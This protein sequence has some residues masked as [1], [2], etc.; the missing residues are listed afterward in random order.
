M[1]LQRKERALATSYTANGTSVLFCAPFP[2]TLPKLNPRTFE[3]LRHV[4]GTPLPS[5]PWTDLYAD[6]NLPIQNERQLL[7]QKTPT[8]QN[9][10]AF[11]SSSDDSV[12]RWLYLPAS[13]ERLKHIFSGTMPL[14]DAMSDPEDGSI[15]V[16]DYDIDTGHIAE[17]VKTDIAEVPS[18]EIPTPGATLVIPLPADIANTLAEDE[19]IGLLAVSL[20]GSD[21][22]EGID[23][24]TDDRRIYEE[25]SNKIDEIANTASMGTYI[26]RGEP[27]CY[28]HVSSGLYRKHENAGFG[29]FGLEFVEREVIESV[30]SLMPN[31]D[32]VDILSELQHYGHHTNLIDFT[33]DYNIALFFACDGSFDQNGRIVFGEESDDI[34]AFVP[35]TPINRVTAQKSIFVRPRTGIVDPVTTV[36][37]PWHLKKHI[38]HILAVRH[39]ITPRS[40]YNDIHGFIR[41]SNLHS[42]AQEEFSNAVVFQERG[43]YTK[44]IIHYNRAIKENPRY[45]SAYNNRGACY[46]K[47]DRQELAVQD[48]N[49]ALAI[50]PRS[51]AAYNN[52]GLAYATQGLTADAIKDYGQVIKLRPDL[53]LAYFNRGV[54]Y[55]KQGDLDS[56]EADLSKAIELK[57]DYADAYHRRG[58]CYSDQRRWSEALSDYGKAIDIVPANDVWY[59]SRGYVHYMIGEINFALN[60][61]NKAVDINPS[62]AKGYNNRGL[63]YNRLTKRC[64]A[65]AEYTQALE[66]DSKYVE[67]YV[68]RGHAYFM[69]GQ[70]NLALEDYN[71]AIA[72][73]SAYR[74]AFRN[75]AA[76]YI[77]LN[78]L[79]CALADCNRELE[80]K[81]DDSDSYFNRGIIYMNKGDLTSAV[82]DFSKAIDLRP[83]DA[84]AYMSRM[85]VLLVTKEWERAYAD[86]ATLRELDYDV[87][88]DLRNDYESAG[89]FERQHGL[90]L[91]NRIAAMFG[92]D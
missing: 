23:F 74:L 85:R 8:G 47:V 82:S 73:D 63:C 43:D 69:D 38:L 89:V 2:Q 24:E 18:E 6:I 13:Q 91:P 37:I 79:E 16:I 34:D 50:S 22:P 42:L 77:A 48:L 57:P 15:Y 75:R 9:L 27:E 90:M 14:L 54:A 62:D 32:D 87:A 35:K 55:H 25:V 80:L 51:A 20:E 7:L 49:E 39:G 45:S 58:Q 84:D 10:L 31:S 83:G 78:Q 33:T 28:P 5:P 64:E 81:S 44:A 19:D 71:S 88:S 60:D 12:E 1:R 66:R 65:V 59:I 53:P 30:R 21:E 46:M 26:F 40:I 70:Y 11:R 76:V 52:R 17:V 36:I 92:Q 41:Y 72:I 4:N 29:K 68:N 67:A 56:A 61:F 86:Y 3:M